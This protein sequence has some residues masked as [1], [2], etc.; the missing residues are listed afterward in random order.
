MDRCFLFTHDLD[1]Q[2][3]TVL[4]LSQLGGLVVPPMRQTFEEIRNLQHDAKTLVV[5]T[6][7]HASFFELE[8]PWLAERKARTAIPFALEDQLSEPI[9]ELHFAF[10]KKRHRDGR[11]LIAVMSNQRL[12][13]I[14]KL[15][16]QEG[17]DFQALTLDWFALAPQE[18][19]VSGRHLLVHR[20]DFKGTLLG[21][22]AHNYLQIHP[23]V[24]PLSFP[25][26]AL[27]FDK[28]ENQPEPY[29]YLWVAKRLLK[30]S[31]LN[32][33]QGLLAQKVKNDWL[34]KGYRYAGVLAGFWFFSLL[35]LNALNLH[36][37]RNKTK[38]VDQH[39]EVLYRQFFPD[40]KQVI[41]PRFRLTQLLG[42]SA[43]DTQVHF[44]YLLN[45][46]AKAM[47]NQNLN[48]KELRYQT[49]TLFVT[50]NSPDFISLEALENTLKKAHLKVRQ[51]QAS[52][53]DERVVALL[54]LT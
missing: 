11:Y 52:T 36:A 10:D 35:A 33:C 28:Q 29:G 13:F 26:S 43:S 54:E 34:Q 4:K 27:K 22:L 12:D 2:G 19:V 9:D 6:A 44:W 48:L 45:E 20:E 40:A 14:L 16:A 51:T 23:S 3:C 47:K 18:V 31:P 7:A 46:F 39:I 30:N 8:L 5:E 25:D 38:E 41:N 42:S 17:I 15:L 32:L 24:T 53:Q 49:N 1:A 21:D 37:L 50:L